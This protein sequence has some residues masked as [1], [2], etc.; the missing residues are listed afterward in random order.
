DEYCNAHQLD[1]AGRLK[2]FERVCNAVHL[3]HQHAIIHRD[4]KPS[5]IIVSAD[6]VPKLIN[7]GTDKLL[8]RRL[9]QT[10][11]AEKRDN[12]TII[13]ESAAKSEYASPEQITG[14]TITTASDIYAM[15][16]VLYVLLTGRRPYHLKTEEPD[17]LSR[18]ICEQAPARPSL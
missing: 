3:A 8:D 6:G 15:G 14:E 18:A 13:P 2:L 4:L 5:N 1:V 10:S 12:A 17:E 7:F 9:G 11:D 16:V